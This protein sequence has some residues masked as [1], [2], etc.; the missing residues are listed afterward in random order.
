MSQIRRQIPQR[1]TPAAPGGL[2]IL[3][4]LQATSMVETKAVLPAGENIFDVLADLSCVHLCVS[5]TEKL[6]GRLE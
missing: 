4:K 5:M 1:G 6:T 3:S 2:G